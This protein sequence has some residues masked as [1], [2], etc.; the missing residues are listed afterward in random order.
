MFGL[1]LKSEYCHFAKFGVMC[2]QLMSFGRSSQAAGRLFDQIP[3]WAF[4]TGSQCVVLQAF[5]APAGALPIL[6]MEATAASF[7]K[8]THKSFLNYL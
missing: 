7:C 8:L 1:F 3:G 2:L 4:S 6:I 5:D